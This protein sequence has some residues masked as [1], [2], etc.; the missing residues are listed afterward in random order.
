MATAAVLVLVV[1]L[2]VPAAAAAN[3]LYVSFGDS[4]G[5]GVGAS[6]GH[7]YF[8]LYC[9]YLK[10]SALVDQCVNEAVAG[11]TSDSALSGGM[12]QKVLNDIKS[13]TDTPV[14]T[15]SLGGNDVLGSPGCQPVTGPAC[16]FI[17]NMRTIL[18]Q[19]EVALATRPGAHTIQWLEYYNPNH[20]NPFGNASQDQSTATLLF[21]S[22][23][24]YTDCASYQLN[25]I[26]FNDVVNCV[27]KEKGATP[28]DGYTPFQVNCTQKDCF[29]D[30]LHPDDKGYGLI[31]DAFRTTPG[32]PVPSTPPPD[33]TWPY[34]NAPNNATQPVVSGSQRPGSV[35]TCSPG[36]WSGAATLTYAYQWLRDN[37]PIP[38]QNTAQY[39]VQA[40]DAG[41]AISC[42]VTA[43]NTDGSASAL[44]NP[45]SVPSS[46]KIWQLSE[47]R[48]GFGPSSARHRGGTL[49][50]FQL[51]QAAKVKIL[52][53]RMAPGRRVGNGCRQPSR[54][55]GHKPPCMRTIWI[56]TLVRHEPPGRDK[57][58]FSG[59]VHGRT[60]K[61]G[62]YLAT[63]LATDSAG[64]SA[65]RELSFTVI[66]T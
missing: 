26:G 14:V 34:T 62:R 47:T 50:A 38:G 48:T 43:S 60:L 25:L 23:S 24:T 29:W 22:D 30:A 19:L 10:S 36:T 49:F 46:P 9:S 1:S 32:T 11:A 66:R 63:F 53:K 15:V 57:I 59:H 42:Q 8:D 41:Q 64:A 39:L 12:V 52:I 2:S 44:S 27:A 51:D 5:A 56:G 55:L 3:T 17:R 35:L 40:G 4:V 31:S 18:N 33:G 58:F 7:S 37:T 16:R 13:S 54:R 21:G 20:D 28:V 65:P 45:V 6:A 61:P